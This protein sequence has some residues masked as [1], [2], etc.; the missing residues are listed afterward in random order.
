MELLLREESCYIACELEVLCWIINSFTRSESA[1]LSVGYRRLVVGQFSQ[2]EGQNKG[3]SLAS[4]SGRRAN[5]LG[6]SM[7]VGRAG[8]ALSSARQ[9]PLV[10]AISRRRPRGDGVG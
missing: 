1:K 7:P 5:T 2:S 6:R 9:A 3:M 8:N 4:F 10:K